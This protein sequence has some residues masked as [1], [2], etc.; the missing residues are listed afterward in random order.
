MHHRPPKFPP[1]DK[2]QDVLTRQRQL[3]MARSAHAYV[4]GNTAQFY[5]WLQSEQGLAM[6]QGPAVWI[7]GDCHVGNLGPIADAKGRV[8]VQIRDLDQTVVGNPAH[9]LIRLGLSLASAARGS[10]LPGVTTA[11]MIERMVEGYEQAFIDVEEGVETTDWTQPEVVAAAMRESLR[12]KWRHLARERIGDDAP[13]IPLGARFW[14]LAEDEKTDLQH[15]FEREE[16]RRLVTSLRSRDDDARLEVLDA[17]YWMKGCSSLG[18]LRYAVLLGIGGKRGELCLMDVKEAIQTVAPRHP[19]ASMPADDAQRVV[20]GARH[21]SPALGERM[22]ATKLGEH[23]VFI[24][25]L[26]PQDLKFEIEA[27]SLEEAVKVAG[28]LA[29]VTGRAHAQQMDG[30]TRQVWRE[31]LGRSRSRTLDAPSWL[32]TSVVHLLVQ[33]EGEY[34]E[35]CR[36]YAQPAQG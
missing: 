36:Q 20:V 17:A 4:R 12:R 2:R 16:V 9:D 8:V 28:F 26:L 27:L 22:L 32:W 25:E 14:P 34:L 24:R 29:A 6:P 35:H 7:C 21:L 18:K 1:F 31:E 33:H 13:K 23:S 30:A 11:R 5:A 15:L 10:D 3:K 19:E